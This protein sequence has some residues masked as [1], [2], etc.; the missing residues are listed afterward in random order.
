MY[1]HHP[2]WVAALD[3]VAAGRIGTLTAV[4]SWFRT[5][6]TTR[7][8]SG[9]SSSTA[10][11]RFRYRLLL[12]QPV[13]DAVQRRAT[14]VAASLRRDPSTGVDILTSGILDFEGGSP[15]SLARPGQKP[16]SGSTSTARRAGSRSRSPST[17]RPIAR[18]VSDSRRA[19]THR[20]HRRRRSSS[21]PLPTPTGSSPSIRDGRARRRPD[22]G[23]ARGRGRQPAGDR[24][25]LRRRA[26]RQALRAGVPSKY[27]SAGPSRPCRKSHRSAALEVIGGDVDAHE[28][29]RDAGLVGRVVVASPTGGS[30]PRSALP[31]ASTRPS[32]VVHSDSPPG[33]YGPPV[34]AVSTSAAARL[35]VLWP[36]TYPAKAGVTKVDRWYGTQSTARIQPTPL[37][38]VSGSSGKPR[39]AR[40]AISPTWSARA[41]VALRRRARCGGDHLHQSAASGRPSGS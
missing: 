20:W 4:Q 17:S 9:T 1:R 32:G 27:V 38:S 5:S 35:N 2:T 22:A 29:A 13:T 40:M 31:R 36:E 26:V 19:A 11:V 18:P 12:G 41:R 23:P 16:T 24:D 6:T 25:D 14:G 21:F 33:K 10:A 39:Q 37:V 30:R 34:K 7:R 28:Q 8:T 15:R 3:F